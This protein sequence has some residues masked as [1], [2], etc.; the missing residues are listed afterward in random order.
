MKKLFLMALLLLLPASLFGQVSISSVTFSSTGNSATV[1]WTTSGPGTSQVVFGNTSGS[2]N[3]ATA[4][5]YT[6][7]TSHSVTIPN[8]SPLL[9][10]YFAAVSLDSS[11]NRTQSNTFGLALCGQPATLITGT[12]NNY[13]QYGTFTASLNEPSGAGATPQVCGVPITM[14]YSG[15]LSGSA[16]FSTPISVVGSWTV[17]VQDIGNIAPISTTISAIAGNND[18]SAALQSSAS[19]SGLITVIANSNSDT[20]FPAFVCNGGSG[21]GFPIH[22][23]STQINAASTT[24]SVNGL[25]VNGVTLSTADGTSVY[26]NGAGG[27][28]TPPGS[29]LSGMTAGQVAIAA[30]ASTVT[31]SYPL[32]GV[33]PG[34][35]TGPTSSY[36][37]FVPAYSDTNGTQ[38]AVPSTDGGCLGVV[39]TECEVLLSKGGS[40]NG[41]PCTATQHEGD[42]YSYD[43]TWSPIIN[44]I[45][46]TAFESGTTLDQRV[47][48][49]NTANTN[50]LVASHIIDS[51]AEGGTQTIADAINI[52]DSTGTQATWLLPSY[53][54]WEVESL[55]SGSNAWAINQYSNT[56]IIGPAMVLGKGCTL[57]G[58]FTPFSIAGY[59]TNAPAGGGGY[60]WRDGLSLNNG[61]SSGFTTSGFNEEVVGGA[62]ISQIKRSGNLAYGNMQGTVTTVASGSTYTV[63]CVTGCTYFNSIP[64]GTISPPILINNALY[65][66]ST[67][68]S[69]TLTLTTTAGNQTGVPFTW[70]QWGTYINGSMCCADDWQDDYWNNNNTG[71]GAIYAVGGGPMT[72]NNVS[73][74]AHPFPGF[75]AFDCAGA[76]I[77]FTGATYEE[78]TASTTAYATTTLSGSTYTM[79]W[80]SGQQFW[81]L[82]AAYTN[83]LGQS[84]GGAQ[85]RD[86]AGNVYTVTGYTSSTSITMTANSGTPP[87]FTNAEVFIPASE[88]PWNIVG[89]CSISSQ[90]FTAFAVS[91]GG[92]SVNAPLWYVPSVGSNGYLLDLGTNLQA[93][94]TA[95]VPVIT[96]LA[97]P[98]LYQNW[99]SSRPYHASYNSPYDDGILLTFFD[100]ISTL[101]V[102]YSQALQP[103]ITTLSSAS[104]IA[105]TSSYVYVTGSMAVSTITPFT[106]CAAPYGCMITIVPASGLSITAAG[107]VSTAFTGAGLPVDLFYDPSST[108]C[109]VP[110]STTGCWA[111]LGGTGSGGSTAFS[112]LTGGT[113]TSAAM[114]IG[115][116]ASL[117]STGSGTIAATS[118]TAATNISGGALGSAPYQSAANTTSFLASPTTSG[119]TFVYAWQPTGSAIDPVAV[120]LAT[121]LASPPAIGGA[122][123]SPGTFTNL[124]VTGTCTG[125]GS[126][127]SLALSAI[128]ASTANTSIANGNNMETWTSALTSNS[129][130]AFLLSEATAATGTGD[131][132]LGVTT[133]AGSTS[134]PLTITDSLTGSQTLP[135]LKIAPTWNTTGV[136]DAGIL[137]NV[138]N[139]ASGTG[140]LLIDLQVG[141]TSEFHVDKAGN[142]TALN[143][144]AAG[145]SPPT[146]CGSA[147][148]IWCAAEGSTAGTPTTG[149]DYIRASSS[150]HQY[151]ISLNDGSEFVSAMNYATG[152]SGGTIPLLNG[153]NTWSAVQTISATNGLDLSAMTG[154]SCLEEV[155]GVVTATGSACGAGS[156]PAQIVAPTSALGAP[157][158]IGNT[159]TPID[160]LDFSGDSNLLSGYTSGTNALS[161]SCSATATSCTATTT[162]YLNASGGYAILDVNASGTPEIVAY[163]SAASGTITFATSATGCSGATA[164]RGC[165]GTTASAHTTAAQVVPANVMWTTSNSACPEL[166]YYWY[167]NAPYILI[168]SNCT[169]PQGLGFAV[170][171]IGTD[172]LYLSN[173]GTGAANFIQGGSGSI[174]GYNSSENPVL[175]TGGSTLQNNIATQNIA[176]TSFTA[177]T[178]A[179][180]PAYHNNGQ[181]ASATV[182]GVLTAR[183][184]IAYQMSAGTVQF[185]I[186]ASAAPTDLWVSETDFFGYQNDGSSGATTKADFTQ[187]TITSATATATS[188]VL[189]PDEY[190]FTY[191]TEIVLKMNPGTS[192]SPSVQL[193][194]LVNS[195]SNT[196]TIEDGTGCSGWN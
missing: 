123:A 13:Y 4:T 39:G 66:I 52:G 193:Y 130:V 185:G 58:A 84:V 119:H 190:A 65:K 121:Y 5:S 187:T 60:T 101:G 116:G 23:G 55:A 107:N 82:W 16:S 194:G 12:V 62:D 145:S 111:P 34:I 46:Y 64:A 51:Q 132:E 44:G 186:K 70:A 9:S 83:G 191:H 72:F 175:V 152:T 49:C 37:G 80:N 125:C 28:T 138:T 118:A 56:H 184:D 115:S 87:T 129:A 29:G 143:S 166:L 134:V 110:T 124:T 133:L 180:A 89:N 63:T 103:Y 150:T 160:P 144:L 137:E 91:G 189:T 164:G 96:N 67:N 54:Y 151:V 6:L 2:L 88:N 1:T 105:P 196:L 59:W 10:Y 136:V 128:T 40:I 19:S 18:V 139:T 149:Q 27:Y 90:S 163:S 32:A 20:C 92:I 165:F 157:I 169:F 26:L 156:L 120:D 47:G 36:V 79:T 127:S 22:L 94:F 86:A 102:E 81:G 135:A 104:T 112:A 75:P 93:F 167:S 77:N 85:I 179:I 33:G 78:E 74:S 42:P 35:V 131:E 171:A 113:N 3:Q 15:S 50:G 182:G 192:N 117:S 38:I 43:C 174:L 146:A 24:T 173:A 154:T 108:G 8:L 183:C 181:A 148:G 99:Y 188:P 95:N 76:K 17:S 25:T 109:A 168:G 147:T 41:A 161:A 114:I 69:G 30:T 48:A 122:A 98:T 140:S 71:G 14:S 142:L 177:I 106:Q 11:N 57:I 73:L 21:S 153:T 141:G 45:C 97:L 178:N 176:A 155:S 170:P 159:S 172:T 126:T 68:V 53:C 158:G 31:S 61:S 100:R 195:T 162:A 7:T